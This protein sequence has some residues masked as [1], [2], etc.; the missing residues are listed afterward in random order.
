VPKKLTQEQFIE[1]ARFLHQEKYDYSLTDY[2]ST[3]ELIAVIC[4]IHGQFS[5]MAGRHI[6][7]RSSRGEVRPQGC[8]ECWKD[9]TKWSEEEL[10]KEASKYRYRV[11]FQRHSKGAYLSALR[12]GVLNDVCAHME[13]QLAERGYW[14]LANCEIEALKYSAR[15]EFMKGSGSAYNAGLRNGWLDNICKH[16]IQEADGYHYMV[17]GILNRRL[18]KA[19][20]GV[21][22]QQFSKRMQMHKKGGSTRASEIVQLE[23]TELVKF[24][25]YCL[26]SSDLKDAE[27]EWTDYLTEEGF[28]VLN[29]ERLFGRTGVSRRI[30]TDD[31][32][33]EEAQKYTSRVEFKLG[34]PRHY[35]AACSQRILDK[36]CVHMRSIRAKNYWNKERCMEAAATCASKDE[37]AKSQAGAYSAA[38]ANEWL[39]EIYRTTGLRAKND[40]S[41]LRPATRKNIWCV[42]DYYYKCWTE[43]DRCGTWRMRAITGENVDKLVKKFQGGWIPSEDRDWREWAERVNRELRQVED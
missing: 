15:G 2:K 43:N 19:Y 33:L 12:K 29:D 6:N 36:V 39:E 41:W 20:A 9:A 21:T 24:T 5:V 18:N 26:L 30:Y 3:K 16:M 11:D 10:F 28:E 34:S 31:Q 4:P 7:V 22:K 1:R 23:D 42:A 13:R 27:K 35:D 8:Q 38:R 25:D 40:M 37:F 17:Y 14:N 32:I